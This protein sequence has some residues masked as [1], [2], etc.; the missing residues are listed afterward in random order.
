MASLVTEETVRNLQL[1]VQKCKQEH[2][3]ICQQISQSLP[4][5]QV[6]TLCSLPEVESSYGRDIF[7][8]FW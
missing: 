2:W 7:K 4:N 6:F 1:T 8:Q 5:F 3:E